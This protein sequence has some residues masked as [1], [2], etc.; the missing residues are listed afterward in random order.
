MPSILRRLSLLLLSLIMP[1]SFAQ[2]ATA[3][4]PE[5][6]RVMVWNIRTGKGMDNE[7]NL[8]NIAKII[9]KN[10]PDIVFLQEVDNKTRRSGEEDQAAKL[11]D[12]LGMH[13]YFGKTINFLGGEYGIAFLSKF[14]LH[15]LT[16]TPLHQEEG[17]EARI[18][19]SATLRHR[20]QEITL[21][22]THFDYRS[23]DT[24][25]LQAG[26]LLKIGEGKKRVIAAGDFNAKPGEKSIELLSS[27]WTWL[28]KEGAP[29]TYPDPK[30]QVEID[31]V[32]VLGMEEVTPLRV[33]EAT[34]ASDHRALFVELKLAGD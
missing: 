5:S 14:P 30:P 24:Q 9:R 34:G 10:D 31:H 21:I 6:L 7:F 4:E 33:Q 15:D 29:L 11:G 27:R 17:E 23:K 12:Y 1:L 25:T 26:N 22:N 19:L 20:G 28:Q 3:E 8:G 13:H 2:S 18:G 32:F 16:I